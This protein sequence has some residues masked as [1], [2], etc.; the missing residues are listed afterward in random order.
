MLIDTRGNP[1]TTEKSVYNLD[2]GFLSSALS[3]GVSDPMM[4]K[5]L[6][7]PYKEHSWIFA[8]V[9]RIV[10]N[11]ASLPHI[12]Y[13]TKKDGDDEKIYDHPLL[14]LFRKP[15]PFMSG[16][17]LWE[18][19]LLALLLPTT[20]TPGGQVFWILES[21]NDSVVNKDK[22]DIPL[23]IYPFNDEVIQPRLSDDKKEIVGWDM[24]IGGKVL[25]RY[26]PEEVIRIRFYNPYSQLHGL[27][28]F[29][30]ASVATGQDV[31]SDIYNT[32]YYDNSGALGGLLTTEQE[33][34]RQQ[35]RTYLDSWNEQVRGAS[36]VGKTMILGKGLEY[37]QFAYKHIDMQ[38]SEQRQDN[39]RRIQAVYGVPDSEISIFEAG[40][41]RATAQQADKNFWQKTLL[42]IDRKIWESVNVNWIEN[43]EDKTYY[44]ASDLDDVEA[45]KDDFS[46]NIKNAK[47]LFDMHVP[48]A[49]ALRI[50]Q[51]PVDSKKYPWLERTFISGW[52]VDIEDAGKDTDTPSSKGEKQDER[53]TIVKDVIDKEYQ[54]RRAFS[55]DYIKT[56]LTA[57]EKSMR[58]MFSKFFV[59]QRNSMMDNVD[60]WAKAQKAEKRIKPEDI[61]FNVQDDTER[62]IN[63]YQPEALEQMKRSFSRVQTELGSSIDW[64][65][66][67]DIARQ[68]VRNREKI[69][70]L[71]NTRTFNVA[72]DRIMFEI[73][74]G[75]KS[76]LTVQELAKNLK[77]G[78]WEVSQ[79]RINNS[80]TIARTE[81][82]TISSDVRFTAFKKAGVE[83]HEWISAGDELVR[84]EPYDHSIDGEIVDVGKMFSNG[85]LHPLDQNGDA[86]NVINCRCVSLAVMED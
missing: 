13:R 64:E 58:Q 19:T 60:K 6:S 28:P 37:Q 54:R 5:I 73:D 63:N 55:E 59:G 30:P 40:M 38:F 7:Q 50:A 44:G 68:F 33:M 75:I 77:E 31:R 26:N 17:E 85:L 42:P 51:I 23:E 3:Y 67:D 21:G 9:N 78:I 2:R 12:L 48:P 45:L 49:E 36:N 69:L 18:A 53:K 82:G 47:I 20:R 84:K 34:N 52:R 71:I 14:K 10:T 46:E 74:K 56:V 29:V 86:G 66:T 70:E 79:I 39:R 72:R 43:I 11:I 16:T 27:S 57:G 1:L 80:S 81:I 4:H 22:G 32:K 35:M 76:N 24:V 41:N 25:H 65:I 15:N 61:L 8:C 62:L 83:K